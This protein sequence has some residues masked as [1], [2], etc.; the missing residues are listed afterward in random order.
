MKTKRKG[1]PFCGLLFEPDPRAEVQ[2]CCGR[3]ECQRARKRQNLKRWRVLHPDHAARYKGKQRAWAKAYP[4]YWQ[5]YRAE[6]PEYA[7]RDNQRRVDSRR[8]AKL[9]ANETGMR[10]AV[11]EKLREVKR[12]SGAG[13]SAN[14][15][16]I[17]RRVI[18]IE[19]C[20]RSTAA[21]ALSA[22]R[23]RLEGMAGLGG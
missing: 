10:Q 13:V 6:H 2:K 19:D 18:A 21:V 20:L 5:R 22:R 12:L 15:T 23:N 3:A 17:L 11:I 14:E 8:R 16:G 4:D 1:C 7:A 9:S